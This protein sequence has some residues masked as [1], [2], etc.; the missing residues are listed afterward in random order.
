MLILFIL[1][2]Y[3]GHESFYSSGRKG[4]TNGYIT[5][6]KRLVK[7]CKSSSDCSFYQQCK[8]GICQG[9]IIRYNIYGLL[10]GHD[11]QAKP[12]RNEYSFTGREYS[13]RP[14]DYEFDF[15]WN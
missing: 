8:E 9:P 2:L 15:D 7:P 14:R 4:F 1:I 13:T 10:K 3:K 6:A 12:V 11:R 5:R